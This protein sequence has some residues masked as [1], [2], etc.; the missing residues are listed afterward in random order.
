MKAF[1]HVLIFGFLVSLAGS[2]KV[3]SFEPLFGIMTA[4]FYFYMPLEAYHTA[5]R[6]ALRAA[7]FHVKAR[8]TDKRQENLWTGVILTVMGGLLFV[9]EWVHGFLEGALKFWPVVLI[10][11]GAYKIREHLSKEKPLEAVEK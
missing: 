8:E 10:G 6:R 5:K 1:V 4:A 11:F 3:G 9:N 2:S 7:G